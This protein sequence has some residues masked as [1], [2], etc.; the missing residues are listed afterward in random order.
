MHPS[1]EIEQQYRLLAPISIAF[2]AWIK[3]LKALGVSV[4]ALV[5]PE[6]PVQARITMQGDCFDFA[7]GDP[8]EQA[9]DALVFLARDDN[10]EPADLVAWAP[11]SGRLASWWGIPMLGMEALSDWLID[12]DG[13]IEVF[14]DPLKWLI[15]ERN[16]LLVVNFANAAPILREAAPLKVSSVTF[17]RRLANL[18]N[19]KPPRILAPAAEIRALA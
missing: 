13:A 3:R 9:V 1:D 6:L 7:A 5:T 10:G 4:D 18:I 15:A 11:K 17:G 2:I 8:G 19:P 12:A 16:G 14:D